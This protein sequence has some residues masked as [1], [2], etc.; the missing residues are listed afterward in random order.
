MPIQEP[1][2]KEP[3]TERRIVDIPGI[4]AEKALAL[5]DGDTELYLSVIRSYAANTPA[6]LEKLREV[7]H[8]TLRG[9]V[10]AVHGLKGSSA[11]IGAQGLSEK[12][13]AAELA[14]KAGD[15]P[16]VLAG[17]GALLKDAWELL[18]AI[19]T[20]LADKDPRSPK[21]R[22]PAPDP[23][24]L[25]KLRGVCERY[26]MRAADEIMERLERADYDADGGLTARLRE[27][28]DVSDFSA[29][30]ARIGEVLKK[31]LI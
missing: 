9:Y 29:A 8:E 31:G 20:W 24:L 30:A 2:A 13:L 25:D 27:M 18:A 22:L 4:D 23:A 21:P 16:A 3:A 1:P 28:I 26:D 14:A 12:A 6:V 10:I 19:K 7:T 11:N 5:Y 17:N 15:L